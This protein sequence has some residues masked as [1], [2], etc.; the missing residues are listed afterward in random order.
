MRTG[1]SRR[2]RMCVQ[3]VESTVR[4]ARGGGAP[5]LRRL[6]QSD[7]L[8]RR[9]HP[10]DG[11]VLALL[12]GGG[13]GHRG[14][15]GAGGQRRGGPLS[16]V[17]L[18]H[19]GR[20]DPG[21]V[22]RG[23]DRAGGAVSGLMSTPGQAPTGSDPDRADST[24]ED[25]DTVDP[26]GAPVP[27]GDGAA[28]GAIGDGEAVAGEAVGEAGAPLP[29]PDLA[30]ALLVG[31]MDAALATL[32]ASTPAT[33]PGQLRQYQTWT[34]RRLKHPRVLSVVRRT[35]D[36]DQKFRAAVD[37]RVLQEEDVLVRLIRAGRHAE[38]LASGEP[39]EAVARVGVALG[40][41]GQAAVRAAED[42]LAR[43]RAQAEAVAARSALAGAESELEQARA[44]ADQEATAARTTREALRAARHELRR[45]ER[46]IHTL[47]QRCRA[48]EQE[49]SKAAATL[50]NAR[51]QAAD[52]Q[53][54]LGGRIA[55]LQALLAQSQRQY[56]ALRKSSSQV[57][58]VVAE[59]VGALE[60]D[61]SAL[62]RAAGLEGLP[63]SQ[64]GAAP[65][66]LPERREPLPVPGG[67]A[68]DDPETLAAWLAT[69]DVLVLVDGANVA[70]VPTRLPLGPIG[71]VFTDAGRTADDEIV[72]RVNAAPSERPVVVVSSDN[73]LRERS[74]ALGASV[75]RATALLGLAS[76]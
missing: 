39:P 31:Y 51:A 12:A 56:R 34:P 36:L 32:R 26:A 61:V 30:D 35:L 47:G 38:A 70:P 4:P 50:Q 71:M 60:R 19:A 46:E 6:R 74:A 68:A 14:G 45:A 52:E 3:P 11:R 64:A 58:P 22:G 16:L 42:A 59:A 40:Q 24:W 62:R 21:A 37:E 65:P 43:S 73:E 48:L 10:A 49:M 66:R 8:R 53:R 72:A 69:A 54:R 13:A 23:G 33:L 75:T 9:L 5:P 29:V 7:P 41:D 67:L 55:E 44:H 1:P 20:G 57:D 18:D 28:D 63:K 15:A 25:T 76:R 27:A 17:W 2:R